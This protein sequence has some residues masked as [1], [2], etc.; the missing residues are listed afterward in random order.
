MVR[1]YKKHIALFLALLFAVS[2]LNYAIHTLFES[3]S[4]CSAHHHIEYSGNVEDFDIYKPVK[5]TSFNEV[6]SCTFC[7]QFQK[8]N[9]SFAQISSL[10]IENQFNNF[11]KSSLF[12]RMLSSN[13]LLD[14]ISLRGPPSIA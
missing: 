8:V 5:E 2:Q 1:L 9:L 7:Q 11:C 10:N 12:Y 14:D 4:E 6:H 3:H 13:F